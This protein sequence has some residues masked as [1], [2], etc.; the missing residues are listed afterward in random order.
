MGEIS[1]N[2]TGRLRADVADRV[3]KNDP[4]SAFDLRL[5]SR[6]QPAPERRP[7]GLAAEVVDGG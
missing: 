6:S 4:P 5:S 1:K 3:G 2:A 7:E